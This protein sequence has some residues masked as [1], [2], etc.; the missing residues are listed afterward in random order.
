MG[1]RS[2]GSKPFRKDAAVFASLLT[3][4]ARVARWALV[5]DGRFRETAVQ[6]EL[7]LVGRSLTHTKTTLAASS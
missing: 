4:Q 7:E 6:A 1:A 5:D 2:S 3:E